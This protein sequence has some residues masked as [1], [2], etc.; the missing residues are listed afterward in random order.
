MGAIKRL[1]NGL[2]FF[3]MAGVVAQAQMATAAAQPTAVP[4]S[5][6]APASQAEVEELRQMVRELA[7]RVNVLEAE[8][9]Q[10]RTVAVAYSSSA[11]P[12]NYAAHVAPRLMQLRL[13]VMQLPW[14]LRMRWRAFRLAG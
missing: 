10:R 2:V 12:A 1:L 7:L 14:L 4:L 11:A 5:T 9:R 3:A 13:R 6:A 8:Q